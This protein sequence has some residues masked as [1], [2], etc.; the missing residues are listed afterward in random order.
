MQSS[1]VLF[2]AL[3]IIVG[4]IATAV[5]KRL[6]E[7]QDEEDAAAAKRRSSQERAGDLADAAAPKAKRSK[8]SPARE[9]AHESSVTA[10]SVTE[11]LVHTLTVEDI[12]EV[13]NLAE[14]SNRN[15]HSAA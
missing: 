15:A 2:F 11:P 13:I 1:S 3:P 14:F 10:P 9:A 7:R 6:V 5:L 4:V 12:P 8:G